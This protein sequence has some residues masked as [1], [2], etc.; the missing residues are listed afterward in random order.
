MYHQYK[1][2]S[3]RG[4]S[5]VYLRRLY[6][7]CCFY[8]DGEHDLAGVSFGRR[9]LHDCSGKIEQI[10]CSMLMD[11]ARTYR[12]LLWNSAGERFVLQYLMNEV[13]EYGK[14]K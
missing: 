14:R 9:R 7:L 8:I 11:M 12:S 13:K 3:W 10:G 6:I 1:I 2:S 5:W 4:K